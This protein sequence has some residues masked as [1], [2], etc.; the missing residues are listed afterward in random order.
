MQRRVI[1]P[2]A[3]NALKQALTHVYWYKSDL[4]S[5]LLNTI[6]NPSILSRLNWDDYKRNIVT[7]LVEFLARDQEKYQGDLLRLISEVTRI[8]DFTHL[9]QLEDGDDKE[10]RAKETVKALS[11]LSEAHQALVD[12]QKEI[13]ARRRRSL[14]KRLRN[15]GV[16]RT[17][18]SAPTGV[19]RTA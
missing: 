6:S 10:Q 3:I 14:E 8:R 4:K 5:F 16:R 11:N 19:Y 13:K 18:G 15:E 12:E 1:A 17:F 9:R 2:A 7:T